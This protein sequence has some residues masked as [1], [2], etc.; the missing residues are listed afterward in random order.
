MNGYDFYRAEVMAW[1]GTDRAFIRI[2]EGNR[3]RRRGRRASEA[4]LRAFIRD[5]YRRAG[6][7]V[8][9]RWVQRLYEE[10]VPPC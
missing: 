10:K 7:P 9:V 1:A 6:I 3:E 2:D 5:A 4:V 8:R